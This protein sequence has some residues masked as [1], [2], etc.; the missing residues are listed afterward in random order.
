MHLSLYTYVLFTYCSIQ[1]FFRVHIRNHHNLF[2]ICAL[3][4]TIPIRIRNLEQYM[5][6]QYDRV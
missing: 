1:C 6:I 5:V 4:T 3:Y 2:T